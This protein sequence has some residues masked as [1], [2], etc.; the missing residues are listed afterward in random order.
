MLDIKYEKNEIDNTI[1][2][3]EITLKWIKKNLIKICAEE[4]PSTSLL[5]SRDIDPTVVISSPF[6]IYKLTVLRYVKTRI[7]K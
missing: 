7:V 1:T 5:V 2:F 4:V 6:V 3:I